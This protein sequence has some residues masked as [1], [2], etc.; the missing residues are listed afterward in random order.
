MPWWLLKERKPRLRGM[1][2]GTWSSRISAQ[3]AWWP[4]LHWR[5][6]P[7]SACQ[8]TRALNMAHTTGGQA[9]SPVQ[10]MCVLG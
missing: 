4:A 6:V 1:G 10:S 2:W 8:N 3:P 9:P 7:V 5:R